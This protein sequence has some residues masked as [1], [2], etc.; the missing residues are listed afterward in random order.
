MEWIDTIIKVSSHLYNLLSRLLSFFNRKKKYSP[1]KTKQNIEV[2]ISAQEGSIEMWCDKYQSMFRVYLEFSNNNP[3]PIEIDRVE[4]SGYTY[5]SASVEAINLFGEKIEAHKK[6]RILL[7]GKIDSANLEKINQA[8]TDETLR[9]D[10]RAVILNK[11]YN[12]RDYVSHLDNV[13]C[14]YINRKS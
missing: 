6:Y 7:K 10:V 1:E 13:R 4:V 14:R 12:I 5:S 3:F 8:A 2:S 9:L 11:F